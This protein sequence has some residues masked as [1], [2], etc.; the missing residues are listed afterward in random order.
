MKRIVFI[1]LMAWC[2]AALLLAPRPA[3]AEPLL[4]AIVPAD[5]PRYKDATALTLMR[6]IKAALDPAGLMN[7]GRVV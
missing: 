7:P 6:K 3:A 1:V 5:L 2:T 4:A